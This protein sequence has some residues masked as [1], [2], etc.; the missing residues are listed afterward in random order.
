M[1]RSRLRVGLDYRCPDHLL[2][3]RLYVAKSRVARAGS[4]TA[5][6][7]QV[8]MYGL[9]AR[10]DQAPTN[11]Q[12]GMHGGSAASVQK[13]TKRHKP[14]RSSCYQGPARCSSSFQRCDSGSHRATRIKQKAALDREND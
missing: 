7:N 4:V 2:G 13:I 9:A 11:K 12:R 14:T 1:E 5:H 8:R 3:A 6:E 10:W